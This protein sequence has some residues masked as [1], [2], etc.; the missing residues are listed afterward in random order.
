MTEADVRF[1]FDP[2]CPFA[3][4]TSRWVRQVTALRDYTV[5]AGQP[6]AE[7]GLRYGVSAG[8]GNL[9]GLAGEMASSAGAP[10]SWMDMM[11]AGPPPDR[12]ADEPT[13]SGEWVRALSAAG[14]ERERAASRLHEILLRVAAR[15]DADIVVAEGAIA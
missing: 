1:Y 8:G 6:D 4:M 14:A 12:V 5:R 13:V 9:P 7:M 2:V 15:Q 3:W 10:S 11:A